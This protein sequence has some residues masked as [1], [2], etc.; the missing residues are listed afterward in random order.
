MRPVPK[1]DI[2]SPAMSRFDGEWR[3][4]V[5]YTVA[6]TS[7]FAIIVKI[8]LRQ[9]SIA[10]NSPKALGLIKLSCHGKK[11]QFFPSSFTPKVLLDRVE[12]M[13]EY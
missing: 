12:A 4:D 5:L 3:F 1:S 11:R 10:I 8:E 13:L 9:L 7:P 6:I 2:A